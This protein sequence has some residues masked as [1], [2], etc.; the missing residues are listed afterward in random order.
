M[1]EPQ[2]QLPTQLCR[3]AHQFWDLIAEAEGEARHTEAEGAESPQQD[4]VNAN[5]LLE[6]LF[7]LSPS[8]TAGHACSCGSLSI[9]ILMQW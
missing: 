5:H 7:S 4:T 8:N 6:D 9:Q 1:L 2:I 3:L